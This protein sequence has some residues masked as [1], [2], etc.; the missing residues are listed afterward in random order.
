M[1][2]FQRAEP[3]AE[4]SLACRC[5]DPFPLM[6]FRAGVNFGAPKSV[7]CVYRH[8]VH[9]HDLTE[10]NMA[11]MDEELFLLILCCGQRNQLNRMR[12]TLLA[13]KSCQHRYWV[14]N[15]LRK[16]KQFGCSSTRLIRSSCCLMGSFTHALLPF[17]DIFTECCMWFRTHVAFLGNPTSDIDPGG[18]PSFGAPVPTHME[19]HFFRRA[20]QHTEPHA[21]TRTWKAGLM[22]GCGGAPPPPELL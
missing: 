21:E 11:S 10:V 18:G 3:R 4:K 13:H 12:L 20:F 19:T 9:A 1:C 2:A 15:I 6:R 5:V 16:R 7:G 22:E 17:R 8:N 14:H